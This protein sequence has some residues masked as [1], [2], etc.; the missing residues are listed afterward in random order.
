MF[1]ALLRVKWARVCESRARASLR[2][3]I[4][5]FGRNMRKWSEMPRQ[6]L[7]DW[8]GM[9]SCQVAVDCLAS[10][11]ASCQER[12]HRQRPDVIANH[13]LMP[14][15]RRLSVTVPPMI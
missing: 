11:H 12:T 8:V 6:N 9:A 10:S 7:I 13:L 14:A 2:V 4:L 5:R 15:A 1:T 3:E